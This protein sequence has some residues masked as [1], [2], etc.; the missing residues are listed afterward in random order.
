[1]TEQ[2]RFVRNAGELKKVA[3]ANR[4]SGEVVQ[5]EGGRAGVVA[6]LNPGGSGDTVT[7]KTQGIYAVNK[8]TSTVF[9]PGQEIWWDD[10][11]GEAVHQLSSTRSFRIGIAVDD[12]AASDTTVLVEINA[13]NNYVVDVGESGFDFATTE[14]AGAPSASFVGALAC[15]LTTTNEAQRAEAL[16]QKSFALGSDWIVEAEVEI[17]TAGDNA[18]VDINLGVANGGH[19]SDADAITESVFV[20]IDGASTNIL[21][22]SDDGTNEVSATDTTV[23]FTAGTAFLVQIDGRDT[24]SVK[25]YINGARV[26]SGTTFNISSATGPLK[27]LSHIEKSANDSPGEIH[28]AKFRAYNAV[29]GV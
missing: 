14:T 25:I 6:G 16:S 20:H 12:A 13:T 3:T 22:E 26:L 11:N 19:A 28:A 18:A 24:S 2:A 4:V 23:D 10:T 5:C 8:N 9:L 27:L 17:A 7:V 21:A 1:M 29:A 15:A